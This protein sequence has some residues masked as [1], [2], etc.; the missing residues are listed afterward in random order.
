M[1][2]GGSV[3]AIVLSEF[4][5]RHNLAGNLSGARPIASHGDANHAVPLENPVLVSFHS[6]SLDGRPL[7]W[8]NLTFRDLRLSKHVD[9]PGDGVTMEILS[10]DVYLALPMKSKERSF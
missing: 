2:S 3:T 4:G 8:H 1:I 6:F 5:G 10:S 9:R 7:T